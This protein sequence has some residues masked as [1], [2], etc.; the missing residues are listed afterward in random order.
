M[1]LTDALSAV[2]EQLDYWEKECDVARQIKDE[3]RIAQC[4]RFIEQC[5]VVIEALKSSRTSR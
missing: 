1:P 3:K 2:Q 4:E 5:R